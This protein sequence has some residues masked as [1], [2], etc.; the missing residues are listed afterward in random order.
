MDGGL[1]R[2]SQGVDYLGFLD[3]KLRDL[4]G[5]STLANEFLQNADDAN[6]GIVA[7]DFGDDA[8]LVENDSQFSD[9]QQVELPECP[10]R[11]TSGRRCDFHRIR[12][13]AG[14]DKRNE[15]EGIGAFG[16][17]F[18]SAYQITDFPEIFSAGRHWKI[19]PEQPEDGRIEERKTAADYSGT[20]FRLPWARSEESVL[21]RALHVEPVT[22]DGI[23]RF[24]GELTSAV[25]SAILFLP[26]IKIIEI[27]LNAYGQKRVERL[28][29]LDQ[30]IVQEDNQTEL[31]HLVGGSFEEDAAALRSEVG[32]RIEKKRKANVTIAIPDS[33]V[34]PCG[35]LCAYLPTDHKTGLPFHI[36]ADF[37]TSSDRKRVIFDSNDYQQKWNEA[38]IRAAA[39][40]FSENCLALRGALGHKRLWSVLQRIEQVAREAE[41]GQR[42]PILKEFWAVLKQE[43]PHLDLVRTSQGSWRKPA[44]VLLLRTADEEK[45]L[46]IL[47]SL[48]VNIVH[49]ELRF[50]HNLLIGSEVGVRVLSILDVTA[51][52]Q[53]HGFDEPVPVLS[54]ERWIRDAASRR[55]LDEE[56][57]T[58]LGHLAGQPSRLAAARQGVSGC[59]I[60]LGRD[61]K[62][63]PCGQICSADAETVAL[64]E[65]LGADI[66]FL[67]SI[68]VV[69]ETIWHLCPEFSVRAALEWLSKIPGDD[70]QSAYNEGRFDPADM[71]AW[72]EA[73]RTEVS[74][75]D[76]VKKDLRALPIFPAGSRLFPLSELE[77]PGGFPDPLG[78]AEVVDVS[79]LRGRTEFLRDLDASELTFRRYAGH[80]IPRAFENPALDA[81]KR[82]DVARL[83]AEKIG[84]IRDAEDIRSGLQVLAIVEC[85]DGRF[86]EPKE[87]YFPQ[88]AVV[89]LLGDAVPIAAIPQGHEEALSSLYEWLGV[90]RKPRYRALVDR[91]RAL[92]ASPP[93]RDTLRL[94]QKIFDYLAGC[95]HNTDFEPPELVPLRSMAWLAARNQPDQWRRPS[96]LFAT[97][98]DYLFESQALF[99]DLP[100]EVQNRATELLEFLGVRRAPEVSQVVAHLLTCSQAKVPV[101]KEVYRF[102]ND[103]AHDPAIARLEKKECL[104]LPSNVY[105][106]PEQVIWGEHQFGR[107]RQRLGSDVRRYAE[108]LSRLHVH[109]TPTC[110]DAESV[111]LEISEE[112]GSANTPLDPEAYAV[113]LACWQML[114]GGLDNGNVTERSLN[115]LAKSKVIP[116]KR[117]IL[118]RPE[119]VFFEDRAGL[120]S[121]FGDFLE[122]NVIPRPLGAWKSMAA[123][124]V[125][126]LRS[127]V[128]FRLVECIDPVDDDVVLSR[129]R[130][131]EQDLLRVLESDTSHHATVS[132]MA[133]LNR[134]ACQSVGELKIQYSLH[135]SEH[136]PPPVVESVLAHFQQDLTSLFFVRDGGQRPW[137]S[138]ARELALAFRPD[139]EP[140]GIA[141]GIRDV[142]AAES[143]AAAKDVLDDLGFP[144]LQQTPPSPASPDSVGEL[145]T[146]LAG[147]GTE[148]GGQ[149][150]T[151][152]MSREEAIQS[153]LGSDTPPPTSIPPG[154]QEKIATGTVGNVAGK[155]KGVVIQSGAVQHQGRLRTY[156]SYVSDNGGGT[157]GGHD[158]A[159]ERSEV[160]QTGVE[161]VLDS[162]RSDGR[163]PDLKPHKHP[164]YDIESRDATGPIV[165]YI[166]V[167][168]LSG[169]WGP[170]GVGLTRVEFEKAREMGGC[171]WLYVVERATQE[172][173]QI[174][175]IQDPAGKANQFFYDDGWADVS[176]SEDPAATSATSQRHG[177]ET[178]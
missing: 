77:L 139:A 141:S 10:W 82:R 160:D 157:V 138:I 12:L 83:L 90:N 101:N 67:E 13:I 171:Y 20:R 170:L 142:L 55:L 27:R 132:D 105:V 8:L 131:R 178:T 96:E 15:D 34:T 47:E 124:G 2:L 48:G 155:S 57:G 116:D 167:K 98:Q 73:R 17:G 169:A 136:D 152:G 93:N 50:A 168:S 94:V 49:P 134:L 24:Q 158:T 63:W 62:L 147:T 117:H 125:R 175:R 59:A 87:V 151:D 84:E 18:I 1:R 80:H 21:R 118:A 122:N 166:E 26:H 173:Y 92:C 163:V 145:G 119:W 43:L 100:R 72:F 108:L 64:F 89:E 70:I 114:S 53:G 103:N 176:D 46:P 113:V 88:R 149:V 81:A 75:S 123:A 14:A 44:E 45:A 172:D 165:R 71:L 66:A 52:L 85:K 164:G 86:R 140:G 19:C 110:E 39:T 11:S 102:L 41:T 128:G 135:F 23:T 68:E 40:A 150:P 159:A 6:A 65:P 3:S 56:I 61:G 177:D 162:E 104:L 78:L 127:A 130:A 126:N 32:G 111:L 38:G 29:E 121:K 33:E 30:L 4:R 60:A 51:A 54:A 153:I 137:P 76:R 95:L 106:K 16:I 161:R 36:N 156:V 42:E 37:F 129:L 31:W 22:Q 174:Y 99:L 25:R 112:F 143:D 115:K 7:F 91:V 154:L 9:C 144:P 69:G 58:L 35:L 79:R 120:A 148:A 28:K 146:S 74:P 107:F 97:F 133:L 109:E 5:Y